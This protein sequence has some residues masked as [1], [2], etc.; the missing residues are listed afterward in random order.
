MPI[1]I[2][3]LGRN[4]RDCSVAF[5]INGVRWVYF[6]AIPPQLNGV[7]WLAHKKSNGKAL[8]YA[9]RYAARCDRMAIPVAPSPSA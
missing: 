5:S 3:Y 2:Q 7:D 1:H 4:D 8:A 6:L 9:K